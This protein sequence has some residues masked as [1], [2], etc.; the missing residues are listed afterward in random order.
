MEAH[1]IIKQV[2]SRKNLILLRSLMFRF[3]CNFF[4]FEKLALIVQPFYKMLKILH[5]FYKKKKK[6][7]S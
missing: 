2:F 7:K 1:I 6:L 4:L 3:V 5:N